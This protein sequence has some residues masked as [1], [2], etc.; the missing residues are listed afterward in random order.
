MLLGRVGLLRR[1]VVAL[2]LPGVGAAALPGVLAAGLG[3]VVASG[4]LG[5]VPAVALLLFGVVLLLTVG[6]CDCCG[7]CC[8]GY[9]CPLYPWS[10]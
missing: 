3:D 10:P 4:V 8:C 6:G 5:G 9:C 2:P 1:A 7:W